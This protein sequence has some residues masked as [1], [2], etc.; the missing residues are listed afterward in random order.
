MNLKIGLVSDFYDF[1]DH[2][3]ESKMAV[4]NG[5]VDYVVV[6]NS[7]SRVLSR[8]QM[9]DLVAH[10]TPNRD[11]L[12]SPMYGKVSALRNYFHQRPFTQVVLHKNEYSSKGEGKTLTTLDDS[13]LSED[14]F[15]VEYIP[16]TCSYRILYLG[17]YHFYLKY[18]STEWRSNV[19]EVQIKTVLPQTIS[20]AK[21]L[22]LFVDS[23]SAFNRFPLLAIDF[24]VGENEKIYVLDLNTA[25]GVPSD[26]FTASQVYN[27]I[28]N[29]YQGLT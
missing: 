27:C 23:T 7:N 21:T 18:S 3:F 5:D 12:D 8:S 16:S 24:V 19:G 22:E 2:L 25:P 26:F 17:Q 15:C 29:Y 10:N 6:R 1:Y 14:D 28:H 11:L 9:L 4:L 20:N 13:W